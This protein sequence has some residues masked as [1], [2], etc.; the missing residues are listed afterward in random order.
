MGG[1]LPTDTLI[2]IKKSQHGY[3][4]LIIVFPYLEDRI[5]FLT[6]EGSVTAKR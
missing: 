5:L 4:L 6:N 1:A 3:Q 2:A